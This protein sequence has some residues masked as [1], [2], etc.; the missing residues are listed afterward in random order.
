MEI[1]IVGRNITVSDRLREYV[2]EKVVKFEQLSDRV[3][4]I[5]VKFSLEGHSGPEIIRVEITVRGRGPVLRAES[6][7]SDK[8]AVFDDTYGKLLERL[9]RAKDRRKTPKHGNKRPAS[10]GEAIGVL[11][12]PEDTETGET[13]QNDQTVEEAAFSSEY[14]LDYEVST[15]VEIRRKS[16]KAEKL[17][18]EEAVDHMELVGHDFFVFVDRETG[19]PSAVYRRK[20]WT[21]GV[22]VLHDV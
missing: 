15:P 6:T 19:A 2:E 7:G 11:A 3:T 13:T 9:R 10:V 18:A 16:F 20:G 14:S 1:N 17:T 22:I 4:D 5:E 21:Y 8:F 12:Q